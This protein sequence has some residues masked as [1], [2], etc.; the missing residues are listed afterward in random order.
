MD[1]LSYAISNNVAPIISIS[2][3]NCESG[4]AQSEFNSINQDLQQANAQGI[5]VIGPAGDP[6]KGTRFIKD[7]LAAFHPQPD[8]VEIVY[9]KIPYR[10]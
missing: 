8:H 5:T 1:S 6:I 10:V 9:S 7:C 4:W 3:G 2:Y